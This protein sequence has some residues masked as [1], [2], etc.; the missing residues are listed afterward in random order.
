MSAEDLLGAAYTPDM[1]RDSIGAIQL[2]EL[3]RLN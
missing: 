2:D 3:R 1:V